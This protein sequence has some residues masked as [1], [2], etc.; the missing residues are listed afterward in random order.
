MTDRFGLL[1]DDRFDGDLLGFPEG[2]DFLEI[3]PDRFSALS[4]LGGIPEFLTAIP[5]VFHSLDLSLGSDEALDRSYLEGLSRL[6]KHFKPRWSSDHL[7]VTRI[8][9]ASL[10]HLTPVRWSAASVERIAA[11]IAEVQGELGIPFLIEN[12]AYYVRIP[13]ADISEG[14]LLHGLVEKTGCG[15]L[16]DVNNLAVNAE[17]HGFDPYAYLDEFPL[18]AVGEIHI[19]GHRRRGRM[20]IDSHGDPVSE[21]VWD[22][23]RFVAGKRQPVHVVLERDQDVP[24]F[25]E[26]MRELAMARRCVAEARQGKVSAAR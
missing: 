24:P 4:E 3:I 5:T 26:L 2:V 16:L 19:A 12:I 7:A 20:C 8:D 21:L 1:Y 13:G 11:K 18:H 15:V 25:G 23:L 17:N 6:A 22:L 9:G 14:E 10:G